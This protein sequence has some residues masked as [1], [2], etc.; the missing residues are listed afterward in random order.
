MAFNLRTLKYLDGNTMAVDEALKH[1]M[2]VSSIRIRRTDAPKA[3]TFVSYVQ[4]HTRSRAIF[5][6]LNCFNRVARSFIISETIRP[7][8]A[9]NQQLLKMISIN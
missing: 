8:R 1:K 9:T 5:R 3:E 4:H 6:R 7:G 2:F